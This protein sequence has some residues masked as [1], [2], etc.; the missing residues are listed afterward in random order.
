MGGADCSAT[1]KVLDHGDGPCGAHAPDAAMTRA[2]T[3]GQRQNREFMGPPSLRFSPH[4]AVEAVESICYKCYTT[5][6]MQSPTRR[7]LVR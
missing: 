1:R 3:I 7:R 6:H 4:A 2:E 5:A